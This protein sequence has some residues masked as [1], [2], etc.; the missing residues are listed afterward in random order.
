MSLSEAITKFS[1]DIVAGLAAWAAYMEA[2]PTFI[3]QNAIALDRHEMGLF[4]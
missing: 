3:E 1:W 2:A 4:H